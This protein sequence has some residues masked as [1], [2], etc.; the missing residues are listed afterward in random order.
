LFGPAGTGK[1]T[2]IA[3][4]CRK[5]QA[6]GDTFTL[7][8]HTDKIEAGDVKDFIKHLQY[9]G[10][11]KMILVAEDIGGIEIARPDTWV[12]QEFDDKTMYLDNKDL[13]A[14]NPQIASIVNPNSRYGLVIGDLVV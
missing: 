1:T 8:W 14:T 7:L 9:E 2:I 3:E 6:D 10:V 11:N 13:K 5:H 12:Y 4:T